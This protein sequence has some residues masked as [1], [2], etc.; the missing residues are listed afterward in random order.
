MSD[1]DT[2]IKIFTVTHVPRDLA[3][4]WLAHLRSFDVAHPCCH[5]EVMADAPTLPTAE[6]IEMIAKL[7]K[8]HAA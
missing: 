3:Q 7:T 6:M 4:A 5:F 8:V 2:T 1:D